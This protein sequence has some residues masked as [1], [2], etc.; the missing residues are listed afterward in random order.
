MRRLLASF[1]GLTLTAFAADTAY[2][3][4]VGGM[5]ITVPTGQ[6]RSVAVPLLQ[7]SAGVGA[8][9]GRIEAVGTNYI[10][11]S[12]A[13]W[14]AATFSDATNPYY[15]R[16]KTGAAAGR[17]LMV[18]T[19]ANTA[20]RVFL[21][22]DSTDLTQ[23]GIVTGASG[24]VYELVLAD[25]LFDLFGS[26]TLQ[27]GVDAGSADNVQVW[28]GAAWLVFYYNTTR[29]RWERNTDTGASPT[30]DTFVIRPDRGLM[31]TRRAGTDLT[32]RVN[33]RVPTV[34]PRHFH[35]RPGTTFISNGL[36]VDITLGALAMQ[37]RSTGWQ[38]GTVP[39]TAVNDADWIQVWGGAAWF[40]FYYD[41]GNARWQRNDGTNRDAFVIPAGRPFMIR[42]LSAGATPLEGVIAMPLPYT[43]SM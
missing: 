23:A 17:V 10:D 7:G 11:N 22:N 38:A 20:T 34:T 5:T 33:G 42:R 3:P 43:I 31:I 12:T 39:S 25:T 36:P 30:R 28:G 35:T 1:L 16:I 8:L 41:S 13:G 37:T 24:D 29:N 32:M 2:S 6:T 18:S 4:P 21:N 40:V 19:T 27:G 15:L 14:T 26:G 9:V